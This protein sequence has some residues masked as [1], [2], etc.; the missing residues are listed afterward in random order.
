MISQ[1]ENYEHLWSSLNVR[2]GSYSVI[3]AFLTGIE[4]FKYKIKQNISIVDI[5]KEYRLNLGMDKY[6]YNNN[7]RNAIHLKKQP[8]HYIYPTL[9]QNINCVNKC[10]EDITHYYAKY[11]QIYFYNVNQNDTNA[12]AHIMKQC[13]HLVI[14]AA[15]Q[16]GGL[17]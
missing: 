15:L 6:N 5:I 11:N 14:G 2:G 7:N 10:I 8:L 16:T 4:E 3:V 9:N 1:L 13:F 12:C 17:L